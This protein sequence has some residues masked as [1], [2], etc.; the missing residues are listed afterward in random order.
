MITNND[1]NVHIFALIA[2]RTFV[3]RKRKKEREIER[4]RDRREKVSK[5][6]RS[7]QFRGGSI[8]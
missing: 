2:I 1:E 3:E 6:E 4:E 8:N 7:T 5:R